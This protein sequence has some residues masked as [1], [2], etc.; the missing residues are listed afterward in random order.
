MTV[1]METNTCQHLGVTSACLWSRQY[2]RKREKGVESSG[3][4]YCLVVLY[5]VFGPLN[6]LDKCIEGDPLLSV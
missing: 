4:G 6:P 5:I 3:G 2:H 1:G